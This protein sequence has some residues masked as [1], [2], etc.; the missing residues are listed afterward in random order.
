MPFLYPESH[1]NFIFTNKQRTLD[2]HTIRGE[3]SILFI[4]AH[5]REFIL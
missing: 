3:K 2:D 4:I 5:R 1:K